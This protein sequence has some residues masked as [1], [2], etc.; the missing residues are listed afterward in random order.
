LSRQHRD[1]SACA[2]SSRRIYSAVKK[3]HLPIINIR[4][5]AIISLQSN[6]TQRKRCCATATAYFTR[7]IKFYSA[8]VFQTG[9]IVGDERSDWTRDTNVEMHYLQ[10]QEKHSICSRYHTC[11]IPFRLFILRC[12]ASRSGASKASLPRETRRRNTRTFL[13]SSRFNAM[14]R[15]VIRVSVYCEFANRIEIEKE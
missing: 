11:C 1:S 3:R 5:A 8:A 10:L 9:F 2:A 15:N 7:N 12:Y 6:R 13:V 4:C 14:Y